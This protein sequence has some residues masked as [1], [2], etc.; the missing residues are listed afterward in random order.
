MCGTGFA[1]YT[2]SDQ[3][4]PP[5]AQ[6]LLMRVCKAQAGDAA[7]KPSQVRSTYK[8]SALLSDAAP[9]RLVSESRQACNVLFAF[10]LD[11]LQIQSD[12]YVHVWHGTLGVCPATAKWYAPHPS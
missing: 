8:I 10:M 5:Q 4:Q 2:L 7:D 11:L 9:C 1:W 6:W 12:Q 3:D